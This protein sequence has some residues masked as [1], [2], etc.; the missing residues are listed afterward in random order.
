MSSCTTYS[1]PWPTEPLS[2]YLCGFCPQY[3]TT[4]P[5]DNDGRV[6]CEAC[7]RRPVGCDCG[8]PAGH[9]PNGIHCRKP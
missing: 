9:V 6:R 2:F 7:R 4:H 3:T 5:P 1:A 8:G